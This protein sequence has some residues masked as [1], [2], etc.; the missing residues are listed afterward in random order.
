[1]EH[2]SP[3]FNLV[4]VPHKVNAV[5]HASELANAAKETQ[6]KGDARIS[7]SSSVDFCVLLLNLNQIFFHVFKVLLDM[8]YFVLVIV[9]VV[10]I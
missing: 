2:P 8:L 4:P 7:M 1:M 3:R 10:R 6:T 5:A 9:K